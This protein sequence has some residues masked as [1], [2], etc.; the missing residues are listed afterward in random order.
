MKNIQEN[1]IPWIRQA[2][3]FLPRRYGKGYR[4]I[5]RFAIWYPEKLK[6]ILKKINCILNNFIFAWIGAEWRKL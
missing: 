2:L 6:L 3:K 4:K 5:K 1:F